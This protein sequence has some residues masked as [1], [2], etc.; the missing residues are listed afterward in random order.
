[1]GG[2]I[3]GPW[4]RLANKS[5]PSWQVWG[6]LAGVPVGELRLQ[7]LGLSNKKHPKSRPTSD[8]VN[9]ESIQL[10]SDGKEEARIQNKLR[11]L[12]MLA[13]PRPMT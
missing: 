9:R 6:H 12:S 7:V 5:R 1:M 2:L 8:V 10:S 3:A 13:F 11:N 4:F